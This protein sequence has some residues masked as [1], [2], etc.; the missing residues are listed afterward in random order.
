M[1]RYY[2]RPQNDIVDLTPRIPLE[3]YSNMINQ[4]QQNLNQAS[5]TG[6][7]FMTDAYGQKFIDQKTRDIFMERARAPIEQALEK[8]FVTPASMASAV[9]RASQELADWKNLNAKHLE[10]AAREQA[11]RDKL[12]ANYIGSSMKNLS[13]M[14]PEGNLIRPDDMDFVAGDREDLT[15]NFMQ[16]YKE[17]AEMRRDQFGNWYSIL[18][19][20]SYEREKNTK[21]GQTKEEIDALVDGDGWKQLKESMPELARA[22]KAQ[23]G[24]EGADNFFREEFAKLAYGNLDKGWAK[25]RDV[26]ANPGYQA[27]NGPTTTFGNG[28]SLKSMQGRQEGDKSTQDLLAKARGDVSGFSLA[29]PFNSENAKGS[30]QTAYNAV[31]KITAATSFLGPGAPIAGVIGAGIAGLGALFTDYNNPQERQQISRQAVRDL[32]KKY[33]LLAKRFTIAGKAITPENSAD[34]LRNPSKYNASLDESAFLNAVEQFSNDPTYFNNVVDYQDER[35][36]AGLKRRIITTINTGSANNAMAI[37]EDGKRV[38]LKSLNLKDRDMEAA[39]LIDNGNVIVRVDG[40]QYIINSTDENNAGTGIFDKNEEPMIQFASNLDRNQFKYFDEPKDLG[41]VT[42][43]RSY[44]TSSNG[45]PLRDSNG[46]YIYYRPKY[47]IVTDPRTLENV[48]IKTYLDDNLKPHY[49][50][51]NKPYQE[52]M[53]LG[54]AKAEMFDFIGG[55]V[56]QEDDT[57]N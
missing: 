34:A 37:D 11:M 55:S 41:D 5:A 39:Q 6:A 46:D 57:N 18:G 28:I 40:K 29:N 8:D 36:N 10:L 7:A 12:G 38:K 42:N 49:T 19:G 4:A 51:N 13:L 1:A 15:K 56:K 27:G 25:D 26:I 47:E 44:L 24:E 20:K 3:F 17:K 30:L 54:E 16:K 53:T 31:P 23:F 2:Q 9:T 32:E 50:G 21:L 48:V 45:D 14:T 33:P 35:I 22:A 52:I 43:I